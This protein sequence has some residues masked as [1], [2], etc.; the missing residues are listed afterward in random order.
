M[1]GDIPAWR[2][3]GDHALQPHVS[4]GMHHPLGEGAWQLPGVPVCALREEE[5]RR[6]RQRRWR[7]G[8]GT[9]GNGEGD[10]GGIQPVQALLRLY[11][12]LPL[13]ES[14]SGPESL[15]SSACKIPDLLALPR[16]TRFH[17][18]PVSSDMLQ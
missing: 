4:P 1:P 8:S 11:A 9:A 10:G 14:A 7:D 15:Q 6:C 18:T 12:T 3:G 5:R 13:E 16:C 17:K 2:A